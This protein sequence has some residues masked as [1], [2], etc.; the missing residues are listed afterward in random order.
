MTSLANA[1]SPCNHLLFASCVHSFFVYI[2]Y[3]CNDQKILETHDYDVW[4]QLYVG[5][6]SAGLVLY[7]WGYQWLSVDIEGRM[8]DNFFTPHRWYYQYRSSPR[9]CRHLHCHQWLLHLPLPSSH[10]DVHILKVNMSLTRRDGNPRTPTLD[11]RF[12]LFRMP[13]KECSSLAIQRVVGVWVA[14]ELGQE[15][16]KDVNHICATV[17]ISEIIMNTRKLP[18]IGDQVWLITSRH[19]EPL[20][21]RILWVIPDCL[22][23]SRWPY[24]SSM[25]GWKILF[26]KPMLGDLKGY[27]S[28]SSTWIFHTPPENGAKEAKS[29]INEYLR[30]TKVMRVCSLSAGPWKRT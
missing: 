3:N 8:E 15:N 25:L 5:D 10:T 6:M 9:L 21:A 22:Q 24:S 20:L 1:F 26:M 19:T 13:H 4:I 7:V 27:W 2:S 23:G 29:A 30:T 16:L 17:R 28:G 11:L 12:I 18:N 14:Q